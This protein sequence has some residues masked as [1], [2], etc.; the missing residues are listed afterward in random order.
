MAILAIVAILKPPDRPTS[1]GSD[2]DR[3]PLTFVFVQYKT[4]VNEVG[5]TGLWI[6]YALRT[7][8]IVGRLLKKLFTTLC[9]IVRLL[10]K[11]L[12]VLGSAFLA[13]RNLDKALLSA[14]RSFS[15]S[16]ESSASS[17][18]SYSSTAVQPAGLLSANLWRS[19][20]QNTQQQGCLQV[21]ELNANWKNP[22]GWN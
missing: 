3:Y 22:T 4:S 10:G 7:R 12:G 20:G 9:K 18:D 19:L 5:L 14:E 11:W 16:S 8:V 13:R 15:S 1:G 21:N 17:S 2:L 6:F